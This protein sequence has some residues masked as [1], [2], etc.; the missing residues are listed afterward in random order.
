VIVPEFE[1]V[2]LEDRAPLPVQARGDH[3]GGGVLKS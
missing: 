1:R 2:L 3:V